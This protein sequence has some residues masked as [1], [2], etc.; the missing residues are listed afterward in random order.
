MTTHRPSANRRR[1]R[2]GRGARSSLLAMLAVS[3]ATAGVIDRTPT[4][5]AAGGDAASPLRSRPPTSTPSASRFLRPNR[6]RA[7]REC[8]TPGG[9]ARPAGVIPPGYIYA[10]TTFDGTLPD[11]QP[12]DTFAADAAG[13]ATHVGHLRTRVVDGQEQFLVCAHV[14]TNRRDERARRRSR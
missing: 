1:G 3:L 14:G 11:P 12:D 5:S 4:A 13:H 6:Q 8:G 10:P 9:F 7:H 2:R